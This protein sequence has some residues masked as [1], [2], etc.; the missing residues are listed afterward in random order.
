M[1]FCYHIPHQRDPKESVLLGRDGSFFYG[2][3]LLTPE[4]T[5][6]PFREASVYTE[7]NAISK[8][9]SLGIYDESKKKGVEASKDGSRPYVDL[10]GRRYVLHTFLHLFIEIF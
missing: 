10:M 4:L 5:P 8:G 2:Y 9:V 6:L 7:M 3:V 1:R